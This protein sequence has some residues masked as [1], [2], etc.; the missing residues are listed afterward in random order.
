MFAK[1]M[2]CFFFLPVPKVP[3]IISIDAVASTT[4]SVNIMVEYE[5]NRTTAQCTEYNIT[6][7]LQETGMSDEGSQ[8]HDCDAGEL[9]V[10]VIGLLSDGKY[11]FNVS[12]LAD[13]TEDED[14]LQESAAASDIGYTCK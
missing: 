3:S 4:D 5:M 1:I 9:N 8:Q 11:E 14:L 2:S 7:R 12:T 10:T 6:W 13:Y